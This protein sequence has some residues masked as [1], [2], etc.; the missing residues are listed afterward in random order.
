MGLRANFLVQVGLA[1]VEVQSGSVLARFSSYV[2]Q[3]EGTVWE[4]R[5][6]AEFWSKHPELFEKAKRGVAEAPESAEVARLLLDWVAGV[7]RDPMQRQTRLVSDTSGFDVSRL[8]WLLGDVSHLYL[9]T[10]ADGNRVYTDT[11]DV[12]SWYLGLGRECDPNA[13]AQK[14]SRL[15][16]GVAEEP[17]FEFDHTHNAA[18]DAA[19]IALRA[20][21]VMRT[22][23]AEP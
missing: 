22:V 7:V 14:A 13:S 4:P 12:G 1:L 3:P 5:C 9:F 16:L 15:A 10:D 2:A 8:D 18:D 20:A 19:N 6:V 17:K 21:W 23:E 11:L